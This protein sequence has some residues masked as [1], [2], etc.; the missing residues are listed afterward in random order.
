MV[1]VSELDDLSVHQS[2]EQEP[3]NYIREQEMTPSDDFE[4]EP[5]ICKPVTLKKKA[6][7]KKKGKKELIDVSQNRH[8]S[9]VIQ[10]FYRKF[11]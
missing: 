9:Q 4:R 11:D 5:E 6:L 10:T 3:H 1:E 7:K 2:L 8:S